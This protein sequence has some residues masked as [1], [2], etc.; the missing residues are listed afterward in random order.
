MAQRNASELEIALSVQQLGMLLD[1]AQ[2]LIAILGLDGTIQFTN[3][4]FQN[5]L[6]YRREELLGRS[7]HDIVHAPDVEGVR[8]RLK[9][10]TSAAG[11]SISERCRFRRRDGSWRWIQFTCRN[12]LDEPASAGILFYAKDVSDLYRMESERQV[13]SE[14]VHALNETSNLDQLLSRIHKALKRILPAENCF[15]ALHDPKRDTFHFPFFVDEYDATPPAQKVGR[16]CTAFRERHREN[17]LGRGVAGAC[18]LPLFHL[19][20]RICRRFMP[21]RRTAI[22]LLP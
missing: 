22:N 18:T 8:E 14:V 5:V 9:E 12:C 2:E 15:V 11:A 1:S 13:N 19:L 20:R 21:G 16:S 6:G 10:V 17:S 7:I 4:T 3:A